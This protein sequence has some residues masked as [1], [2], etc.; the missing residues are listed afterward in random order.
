MQ[1]ALLPIA[2]ERCDPL[3]L[4]YLECGDGCHWVV[5]G[6]L[7]VVAEA[8]LDEGELVCMLAANL[9]EDFGDR[10]EAMLNHPVLIWVLARECRSRPE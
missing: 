8:Q 9:V 3:V 4:E 10:S 1:N 5:G 6:G 7:P 2:V